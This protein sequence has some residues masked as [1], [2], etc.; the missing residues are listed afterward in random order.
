MQKVAGM[1]IRLSRSRRTA[2]SAMTKT[3]SA[4]AAMVR[5]QTRPEVASLACQ[6]SIMPPSDQPYSPNQRRK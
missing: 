4:R 2:H 1:A 5:S 3:V 6:A